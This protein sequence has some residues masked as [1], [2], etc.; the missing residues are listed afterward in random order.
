MEA[1]TAAQS[2]CDKSQRLL[3]KN[4]N[5]RVARVSL[6]ATLLLLVGT[7]STTTLR[8]ESFG[9]NEQDRNQGIFMKLIPVHYLMES[10]L[11]YIYT[12]F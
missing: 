1:A 5:D 9:N 2:V 12:I 3:Y 8:C 11:A 6:D 7:K 10:Y 4:A